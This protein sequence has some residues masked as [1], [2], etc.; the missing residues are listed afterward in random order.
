[1]TVSDT[2]SAEGYYATGVILHQVT[3]CVMYSTLQAT[4]R[5]DQHSSPMGNYIEATL[6]F[7]NVV[8]RG[9]RYNEINGCPLRLMPLH[10]PYI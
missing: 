7:P 2:A 8:F 1:V 4:G 3:D 5:G 9:G 10:G 6:T